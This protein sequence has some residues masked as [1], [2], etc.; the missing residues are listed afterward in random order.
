[1]E[2]DVKPGKVCWGL[3]RRRQFVVPTWRG[4]IVL[5][6]AGAVFVALVAWS[7]HP[8]LAVNAPVLGGVL[9]VEGWAPDYALVEAIAEFQRRQAGRLYVSGGPLEQGG[10]LSDYQT[11][12]ELGAATLLRLGLNTNQV[13]AV[14][15]PAVR[16][17]RTYASALALKN[18]LRERGAAVTNVN[19][20]SIGPHCRRTR[21]LYE[22]ALGDFTKVGIISIQARDY[23]PGRWWT[24][25]QGV[26][27]VISEVI[28]YGYAR[29]LFRAPRGVAEMPLN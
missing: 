2:N 8:F 11:F 28:A 29:F 14:P 23:D 22:K 9:V 27:T 1:M 3:L 19:V 20:S 12:A 21:L 26:R 4:W 5:L 13:Q 25:S 15:A 10:P 7:V 6:L 24:S 16:Q 18:W 17:D